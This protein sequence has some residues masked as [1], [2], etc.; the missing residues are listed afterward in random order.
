MPG[1]NFLPIYKPSHESTIHTTRDQPDAPKENEPPI[2]LGQN[3]SEVVPIG[4]P[5]DVV[6]AL[7]RN[8]RRL[9]YSISH[10]ASVSLLS[11]ILAT[12]VLLAGSYGLIVG[13]FSGGMQWWAAPLKVAGGMLAAGLICAPS[14][15]I[16][17]CLAGSS[18]R[19]MEMAGALGG[20]TALTALLLVGFGPVA[21]LFSQSTDSIPLMGFLHLLFWL[22]AM[23]FGLGFLGKALGHFGL[24]SGTAVGIWSFLFVLVSLQMMTTLR[25]LLGSDTRLLAQEKKFFL[26]QWSECMEPKK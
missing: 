9:L 17:A 25:P 7:L 13:S 20:M 12:V 5:F 8:P 22:V 11:L 14:L 1:L 15:Y 10:D 21:W 24:R 4:T 2:P 18:A 19:V 16:F 26:T 23:G 3:P 6:E